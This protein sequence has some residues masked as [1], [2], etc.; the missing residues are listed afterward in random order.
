MSKPWSAGVFLAKAKEVVRRLDC[1]HVEDY[2]SPISFDLGPLS[3][4]PTRLYT[5][6][7][8]VSG[9]SGPRLLTVAYPIFRVF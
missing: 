2:L 5:V 3:P 6:L 9:D 8:P 7:Y 1:W 4:V